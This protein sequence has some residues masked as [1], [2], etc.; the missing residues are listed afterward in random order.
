MERILCQ[1]KNAMSTVNS[2]KS[3]FPSIFKNYLCEF[4]MGS[5]KSY[6]RQGHIYMLGLSLSCWPAW[7]TATGL[8][9]L[10]VD[11]GRQ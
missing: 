6:C 2:G 10:T 1:G 8:G 11:C 3:P 5:P 7:P 4:P 9:T